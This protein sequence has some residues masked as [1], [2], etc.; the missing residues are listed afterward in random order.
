[1]KVR[2]KL[3]TIFGSARALLDEAALESYSYDSKVKGPK[4]L[5]VVFPRSLEEIS[6]LVQLAEDEDIPLVARGAGSGAVGGAVPLKNSIIVCLSMMNRIESISTRDRVAVVEAGVV[7]REL[8]DEAEKLGLFYPPDPASSEHS[9]IGGNI[10]TNAGGLR[11]VKYGV[12]RNYVLSLLVV[13]GGG[14]VL[15]T[16]PAVVKDAVGLDLTSLFV[17]S[18][19]TLGIIAKAR[20]RLIPKPEHTRTVL[21][22][23]VDLEAAIEAALE[24]LIRAT[25]CALEIIDKSALDAA[26]AKR[27]GFVSRECGAALLLEFD[28]SRA[29]VDAEAVE[30]ES[31]LIRSALAVRSSEDRRER[32]QL[33]SI[34]RSL[35]PALYKRSPY[36]VAEDISVMPSRIPDFVR[37]L[38]GICS[39]LGLE[40]AVYGHVGDGN[41]HV[42]LLPTLKDDPKVAEARALIFEEV[43][44]LAGSIS[45]E[46]GVG[47]S[48]I[49]AARRQLGEER[50]MAMRR[51]KGVFDPCGIFNPSRGIPL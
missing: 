25:P 39:R 5:A 3:L 26:E 9:T 49:D 29:Q 45:G 14:R 8:Q 42:N 51:I 37:A 23:F 12:T 11:A 10:A 6:R 36:K 28:G 13:C 27:H 35:S 47:S 24:V 20:L 38:D 1:M 46:H 15:D 17:G 22:E 43:W 21:A 41:L 19:G 7:T 31:V 2:R 33:W 4:P 32:E 48:R 34:R 18:E 44:R 30:V 40:Y 50:L 16:G